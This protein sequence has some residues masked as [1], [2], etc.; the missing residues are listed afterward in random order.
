MH[1]T[2]YLK[3]EGVACKLCTYKVLP[4][5]DP[6]LIGHGHPGCVPGIA[7]FT[8]TPMAQAGALAG[9]NAAAHWAPACC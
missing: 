9:M 5:Q 3:N 8:G 4:E 6:A 2:D 7:V 1:D